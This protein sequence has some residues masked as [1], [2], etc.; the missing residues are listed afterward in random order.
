MPRFGDG[1]DRIVS[2]ILMELSICLCIGVMISL[3]ETR[4]VDLYFIFT[5]WLDRFV[6]SVTP[7]I[8]GGFV[9][10]R[11]E[12]DDPSSYDGFVCWAST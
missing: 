8:G 1:I 9:P 11:V 5:P 7:T 6:P 12:F 3:C 10:S 2:I 4:L